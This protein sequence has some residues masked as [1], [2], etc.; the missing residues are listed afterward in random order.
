MTLPRPCPKP[1]LF[2][3]F[4]FFRSQGQ[5]RI[6]D[7]NGIRITGRLITAASEELAEQGDRQRR[8]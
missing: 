2:G 5:A 8:A 4:S 6:P 3:S 1:A 7:D